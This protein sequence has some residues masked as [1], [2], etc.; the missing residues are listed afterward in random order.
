M[1][2]ADIEACLS[3]GA[4][5]WRAVGGRLRAIGLNR[6]VSR[7]YER[8]AAMGDRPRHSP[9]VKWH[10]RRSSEPVVLAM[11]IFMYWDAVSPEEARAALGEG[12]PLEKLLAAGVLMETADGRIVSPY[13]M[14]LA[15]PLFIL[16]DD[17]NDGGD[18]VMGPG[19]STRGLALA[20]L[21]QIRVARALDVGCGAGTLALWLA[22]SC[23]QVVAT[24]VSPRA[25]AFVHINCWLNAITNVECRVGDMYA[26]V[27]GESF[28]LVIAQPPFVSRDDD[29]PATTFLFGGARGDELPVRM[30]RELGDHLTPGGL[31]ILYVEW[32]IVEGDPS[33]ETR[34][35]EA[36]GPLADRS[37]FLVEWED[38][39]VEEH[40]TAYATIGHPLR[41]DECERAAIRRR[42][43]FER[44][45]IRALRPTFTVVR[46][47]P[48]GTPLGWTASVP[49]RAAAKTWLS[50]AQLDGRIEARDLVARG[51]RAI[52]DARL[53]VPN[54]V[55]LVERGEQVDVTFA[56][57]SLSGPLQMSVGS[58]RLVTAIHEADRAGAGMEAF[59]GGAGLTM[60]DVGDT[61]FEAVEFAL[62]Q[63]LL[64]I[65]LI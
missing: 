16:S 65:A 24:D 37:V 40:C 59:V 28:D 63:G 5:G 26:P 41:D 36:V 62:A 55:S 42:E 39:N 23:D 35:R 10:L 46:R 13:L 52:E 11:R 51:R 44:T 14:R 45:K 33:L 4:E 21:P 50:R 27:A 49:G 47:D 3:F 48:E 6:E 57:G 53:R 29:A 9:M 8:F 32:P 15:G 56:P 25:A 7:P 58:A 54:G 20:S 18:A 30:L 38:A 19:T 2:L 17:V 43:H 31:A 61:V 1:T 60:A 34:V 22:G 64:E 12:L